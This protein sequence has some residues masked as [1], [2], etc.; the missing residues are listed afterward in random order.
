MMIDEQATNHKLQTK[1]VAE[2]AA[3]LAK[4][5]ER[6]FSGASGTF[7]T[8]HESR[9]MMRRPTFYVGLPGSHEVRQVLWRTSAA[10][11]S[12]LLEPD[13]HQPANAWLYVCTDPNYALEKLAPAMRRNVRRGLKELIVA[14]LT[15][16]QLLSHGS[17]AFCDT[18]RRVGLSDGTLEEFR[19]F[20]TFS[21][22][23]PEMVFLGAWR[24][25][26]L[27]AFLS[28]V[29]V[30][31]WVEIGCFSRDALLQYRP[32]DTLMYSALFHYLVERK[33]RVVS[34]GLSSIQAESN[35]AGLHR[36]KLKVGFEARPVHRAFMPHP[37][38]RPFVNRLTLWS[39]NAALQFR[40]RD[41]RLKK[42]GGMLA[43]ML[44]DISML[45]AAGSTSD[46]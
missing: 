16:E 34:Y 19:R 25:N 32:N 11:A 33:C 30:E 22:S 7:W 36:F 38:L 31:D 8:R 39:V 10:V 9:A 24:E 14:P 3:D 13:E 37:L 29:E 42:A 46:E 28:I 17:Q 4:S 40:P 15:S 20:F 45:D 41:R 43:C 5:G 2:Y 21:T 27:A 44:G 23:L 12:Y 18:R 1:T 35:A 6:I 26:Q